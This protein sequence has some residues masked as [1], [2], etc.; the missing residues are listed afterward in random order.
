MRRQLSTSRLIIFESELFR[1]T[2]TCVVTDDYILIVDPNW[3]PSEVSTIREFAE[4]HGKGKEKYLLFTHSD[5]DHIIGYGAF[6]GFTTIA[7]QRFVD[8]PEASKQLEQ[9]LAW[10]D[11]YYIQR[12]YPLSYPGIGQPISDEGQG[13]R[14]GEDE[15]VFHQAPGHNYDGL[16]TFNKSRGILIVGDYLSNIE[17]PYVYHSFADYRATLTTLE[18]LVASGEV[19]ILI[20]GHGD[21]TTKQAEMVQRIAD[22][23]AY[24]D[25]LTSSVQ[26]GTDF[27]FEA[28]VGRYS[29]PGIMRKFHDKNVSLAQKELKAS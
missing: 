20:T 24:L 2:S 23:R 16:I 18:T 3:L 26:S 7:S 29:F 9:T 17:F 25:G 11:E 21:H 1:T 22:S 8:N 6:P 15:Y 10:D 13:M 27:D 12:E 28:F 19:N 4:E 14:I 5:Y